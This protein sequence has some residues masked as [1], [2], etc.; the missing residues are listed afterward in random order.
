M[1]RSAFIENRTS[2]Y[3]EDRQYT[4]PEVVFQ[5]EVLEAPPRIV[6][7]L[8]SEL[9]QLR[10]VIHPSKGPIAIASDL[11]DLE[12]A[13]SSAIDI[14]NI[15]TPFQVDGAPTASISMQRIRDP[16]P[17]TSQDHSKRPTQLQRPE[18][19]AAEKLFDRGEKG[20]IYF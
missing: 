1:T 18:L 14:E 8:P 3:K 19:R 16:L 10:D 9:H 7:S 17:P 13:L 5:F 6:S 20:Y 2:D 11:A 4:G 15:T 12:S